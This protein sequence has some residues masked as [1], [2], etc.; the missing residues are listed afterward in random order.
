VSRSSEWTGAFTIDAPRQDHDNNGQ[1]VV[2]TPN[3]SFRVNREVFVS[4]DVLEREQHA[5]FD[6]CWIYVGHASELRN[7]G[8]FKTRFV[9]PC[10]T[11]RN[12]ACW[13]R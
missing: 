7:P 12:S 10:L 1:L 8:D 11:P 9:A 13:G 5:L 2:E 3:V 4:K 6:R